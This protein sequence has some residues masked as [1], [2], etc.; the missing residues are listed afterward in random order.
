M[1][2]KHLPSCSAVE[3]DVE[4]SELDTTDRSRR[5]S[6]QRLETVLNS[7]C[8]PELS[9]CT[10]QTLILNT[11]RPI[12]IDLA[13]DINF[14]T[15]NK[16][17]AKRTERLL[18]IA[19][20]GSNITSEELLINE[21]IDFLIESSEKFSGTTYSPSFN[22]TKSDKSSSVFDTFYSP[23][24]LMQSLPLSHPE[25]DR[26]SSFYWK[27][28]FETEE[29][30]LLIERLDLDELDVGIG[31][32]N[33]EVKGL[34]AKEGIKEMREA[35]EARESSK[36][37]KLRIME[38]MK[39]MFMNNQSIDPGDMSGLFEI[40]DGNNREEN[41]SEWGCGLGCGKCSLM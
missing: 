27:K 22:Y 2:A 28:N 37:E 38:Q 10:T 31:I 26:E 39:G 3:T 19:S 11:S 36:I 30:G 17:T 15:E 25:S 32:G 13:P 5:F 16:E 41:K 24:L 35:M 34:E 23:K 18:S 7:D 8:T 9:P 4:G 6:V 20:G 33:L 40:G 12:K 21:N 1:I 29:P 14:E